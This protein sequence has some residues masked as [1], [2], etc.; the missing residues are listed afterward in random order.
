MP[1][2]EPVCRNSAESKLAGIM[3]Y[4]KNMTEEEM[5]VLY[6]SEMRRLGYSVGRVLTAEETEME[7]K[8]ALGVHLDDMCIEKR[9]RAIN[10][11][12][13]DECHRYMWPQCRGLHTE[14]VR[15]GLWRRKVPP[16]D[17]TFGY[18][19]LPPGFTIA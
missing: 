14:L 10:T 13:C 4:P 7:R 18:F 9:I 16:L 6:Q 12:H 15:S 8:R 19:Y 11:H 17:A 2:R 1:A 5:E 3:L